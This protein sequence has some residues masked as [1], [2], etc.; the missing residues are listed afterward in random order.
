MKSTRSHIHKGSSRSG[1]SLGRD[2]RQLEPG[3]ND[4]NRNYLG[5]DTQRVVDIAVG[6]VVGTADSRKLV[7][8]AGLDKSA[9]RQAVKAAGGSRSWLARLC[10][11]LGKLR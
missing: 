1:W 6:I 5:I 3:H 10:D 8:E 4:S 11:D 2:S 7:V 9:G